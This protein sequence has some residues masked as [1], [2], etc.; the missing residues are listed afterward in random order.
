[1]RDDGPPPIT[2]PIPE[3]APIAR[4]PA[5]SNARF[6]AVLMAIQGSDRAEVEARLAREHGLADAGELL[7]DVFGRADAPA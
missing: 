3:G 4:R 5:R 2:D 7:D 6:A 1:V